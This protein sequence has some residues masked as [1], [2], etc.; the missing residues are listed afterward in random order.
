M[1]GT[2]AGRRGCRAGPPPEGSP[3]TTQHQQEKLQIRQKWGRHSKVLIYRHCMTSGKG[4]GPD[5]TR[6]GH[7]AGR[8]ASPG[9]V[10]EDKASAP[11]PPPSH[12][13]F[14]N[15]S[16]SGSPW[17]SRV[18]S[19]SSQGEGLPSSALLQGW[20]GGILCPPWLAMW[21]TMS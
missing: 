14:G 17:Q 4:G 3:E 10:Q 21:D 5:G 12:P 15:N 11:L 2:A 9:A 8:W 16:P 13:T 1:G 6:H 18:S 7:A 19:G 20:N